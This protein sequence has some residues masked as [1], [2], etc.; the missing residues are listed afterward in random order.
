[1]KE[2]EETQVGVVAEMSEQSQVMLSDSR[3]RRATKKSL[4]RSV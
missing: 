4:S 1:M 2:G 3:P